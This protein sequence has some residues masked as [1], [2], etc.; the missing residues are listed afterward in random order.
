MIESTEDVLPEERVSY[1]FGTGYVD[2]RVV[3]VSG[4]RVLIEFRDRRGVRRSR[5]HPYRL[6]REVAA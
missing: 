6:L 1:A 2:A 4:A 5:V 3:S